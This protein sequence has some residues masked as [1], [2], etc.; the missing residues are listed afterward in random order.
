MLRRKELGLYDLSPGREERSKHLEGAVP[1]IERLLPEQCTEFPN[2]SFVL[3][4]FTRMRKT[5]VFLVI[6]D[7]TER[8]ERI[9]RRSR[10]RL[11]NLRVIRKH[12]E[13][14]RECRRANLSFVGLN[15]PAQRLCGRAPVGQLCFGPETISELPDG[16]LG[17]LRW[18]GRTA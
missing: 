9:E 2:R 15:Q 1:D 6:I 4:N 8:T 14:S 10:R 18:R 16:V 17:R 13:E 5:E 11:V 3:K 7:G 12:M